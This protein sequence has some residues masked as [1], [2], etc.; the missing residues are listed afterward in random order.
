MQIVAFMEYEAAGD[1]AETV[2][3]NPINYFEAVGIEL[4]EDWRD[5]LHVFQLP[6][7][8]RDGD[9]HG[10]AAEGHEYRRGRRLNHDVRA[11]SFDAFG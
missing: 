1:C 4:E 2:L 10:S 6:Q 5:G 3:F 9:G 8:V 7:F 11:D